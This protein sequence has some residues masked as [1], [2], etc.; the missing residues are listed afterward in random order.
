MEAGFAALGALAVGAILVAVRSW[1]QAR[2]ARA[3]VDRLERTDLLT[4]VANRARLR[5]HLG[6]VL[7]EGRRTTSRTA[8]IAVGLQRVEYLNDTYGHEA[9]DALLVA[10]AR[11]LEAATRRDELLARAGGP[12]FVVVVP[13]TADP[14]QAMTRAEELLAPL[15]RTYDVGS[16]RIRLTACAGVVLTT[17]QQGAGVDE[18]LLDAQVAL[19]RASSDGPGTIV[20]YD[21]GLRDHLTP[22]AAEHRLRTAL[23]R[24]EFWVLY[25]PVVTLPDLRLVG[26]EALLRWS[27]PEVGTVRPAQF[28]RSLEETGLIVPVGRWVLREACRQAAE[29]SQRFPDSDLEVTVNVSPRQLLQSD[30]VDM[31][32]EALDDHAVD[33]RRLCIEITEGSLGRDVDTVWQVLRELRERGVALTLD[34]FGTGSSALAYL[35]RFRL[36]NLKIDREFVTAM[37]ETREDAALVEQI[38]ALAHALGMRAVAEGVETAAQARQ[39]TELGCDR[40]QGYQFSSPQPPDVIDRL[41]ARGHLEPGDRPLPVEDARIRPV[42]ARVVPPDLA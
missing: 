29:W 16:D 39:L 14:G 24:G 2:R 33:P 3:A 26:V 42:T 15:Q 21:T 22:S 9:G 38:V 4:G 40:A 37:S 10:A 19:Q 20:L 5:H 36:D 6:T 17:P 18:V 13:D 7:D 12:E 11:S 32:D 27:D 8:V 1:Q 23:E 31:V 30:F 28:L 41:L 35:R 34:D 25:L